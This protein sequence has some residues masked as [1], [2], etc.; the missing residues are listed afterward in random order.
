MESLGT[1]LVVAAVLAGA[2]TVA[3]L[4]H[5]ARE[6]AWRHAAAA[7]GVEDVSVTHAFG[8]AR[9]LTGRVGRLSVTIENY[10]RS[11]ED[12]GT[13][14][15]VSGLGLGAGDITVRREGFGTMVEKLFG[16]AELSCG[17]AAFDERAYIRGRPTVVHGL[18]TADARRSLAAL[19]EPRIA[20]GP[21]SAGHDR[22][23]RGRLQLRDDKL[24][25]ELRGMVPKHLD[26]TL[27]RLLECATQ[28]SKPD[29][30]PARLADNARN[31]PIAAVRL[32]N[33]ETLLTRHAGHPQT[34][35][36]LHAALG[37]ADPALRLRAATVLGGEGEAVLLELAT[38][39]GVPQSLAAQAVDVLGARMP[40]ERCL[41][42]LQAAV[43][44]G[45]LRVA[46]KAI[47][48]LAQA[49]A[50]QARDR[51]VTILEH[52]DDALAAAAATAL[53]DVG[54][55]RV[56][57]DLIQMLAADAGER[58][59][60]AA[61]ALGRVGT[62]TAVSPLREAIESRTLDLSF[63]Q[64]AK[65]A[66]AAIQSRLTGANAGQVSLAA[67]TAGDLSLPAEP[68]AGH[69]ALNGPSTTR[70]SVLDEG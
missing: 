14:V 15:S 31:D 63:R 22:T 38:D 62:V 40:I 57:G 59:R 21:D 60:A 45:R 10:N 67:S 18:L 25:L 42:L 70:P 28:L 55:S 1:I 24:S 33:L 5:S 49:R 46:R 19:L 54:D 58:R 66:I 47:A 37:D 7:L 3:W 44:A 61:L 36:A 69:L 39:G 34:D 11:K 17:D 35:A 29:D 50:E 8:W 2:L 6:D 30:L 4:V 13:R 20:V 9:R 64:A 52:A 48:T 65:D 68:A 26:V 56:E 53:G 43:D 51:L 41:D 23:V 27:R 16:E 32:A 12:H